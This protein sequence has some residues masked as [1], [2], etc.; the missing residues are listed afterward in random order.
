[1]SRPIALHGVAALW[2]IVLIGCAVQDVEPPAERTGQ[3][4]AAI[5][6]LEA[7][8][9]GCSTLAV[10]GLSLQIIAQSNC[11]SPGA[12][13]EIPAAANVTMQDTV[14]PFLEEP[15]QAALV[16]AVTANPRTSMTINSA[17]RTVAQQYLLYRWYQQNR[18]SISLAATPGTSNHETGLALDISQHD[19]WRPI[20]ESKGFAW[21]GS[22]DP[23]HFDYAGAGA[24]DYRGTDVL[25]FQMLWNENHP[26]DPIDEDGEWG[27]ETEA[28]MIDAPA[29][30]FPIGASCA[31]SPDIFLR[32]E[33]PTA[34]DQ[35]ADGAS[36][37]VSDVFEGDDFEWTVEVENRGTAAAESVD[38][39]LEVDAALT[40]AAFTIERAA[41]RTAPPA[42]AGSGTFSS[43]SADVTI[44]PLAAGEV[45]FI[46]VDLHAAAYSVANDAPAS[47]RAFVRE[48]G[49][50][51]SAT[52]YGGD[53]M[54]DGTQ[55]FAGGRLEA[56]SPIDVYSHVRWSFD[57]NRRE[58]FIGSV[59]VEVKGDALEIAAGPVTAGTIAHALTPL[60]NVAGTPATTLTLR[61]HRTPATGTAPGTAAIVLLAEDDV[62]LTAGT[63]VTI[64]LPA[65]GALHDVVLSAEDVAA[66]AGRI[67]RIAFVP[68]E[69]GSGTAAIDNLQIDGA[70]IGTE[71]GSAAQSPDLD[72]SC[73]CRTPGSNRGH[74]GSYAVVALLFF[75]LA[76]RRQ[77]T[78]ARR[79]VTRRAA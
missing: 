9:G 71:T 67:R 2:P 31:E 41:S 47:A 16:A 11:I 73:S 7:A 5:S 13:I 27:P 65:D 49:D 69:S 18:C 63:R 6:V 36:M 20:L 23:V 4:G 70:A 68:F 10:K 1:M 17:L 12:F 34:F 59:P 64:D 60:T 15:A 77:R 25:A 14:F 56:S 44:E 52:A 54:N 37:G 42:P 28:R 19:T 22:S 78:D 76:R 51:Y 40:G 39:R 58:G 79:A 61:A 57:S 75:P 26:D 38:L 30:G 66:L 46:H 74:D 21:L 3:A 24:V 32:A 45:A 29:E 72:D 33:L 48:V 50:H 62:D 53:V 43:V 8:D 35:F 55:T